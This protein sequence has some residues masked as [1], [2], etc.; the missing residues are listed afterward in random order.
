M[1]PSFDVYQVFTPTTQAQANF[2]DRKAINDQLVDALRTPGKQ[3]IVYG[4]SGS[5]KSTLL[6]NK[7]RQTYAAHITTQCSTVMTYEQLL[8]DAFDQLDQYYIEGRSTQKTRSISPSVVADFSRIRASINASML[9][10]KGNSESR[11]IPPQLTAQRLAQFL[12]EQQM[13]WVVEDFHKMPQN[14]KTP[15]AQSMKVFSDVSAVYPDVKTITIGATDTARQVVVYDP[16]MKNRVSELLVPLMTND[17]LAEII[18][19]GQK[20]L[21]I[22]LSE[23]A[24]PIVEYSVGVPSV[25]HQLAL[26]VCLEGQVMVTQISLRTLSGKLLKPAVA[27]YVREASDTLKAK[28]DSALRRHRVRKFDNCRLILAAIA[29]GPLSGMRPS[30]IL[31]VIRIGEPDYPVGNL[32]QYLKE[33]TQDARGSVIRLG[34]DGTYRFID[35]LYHTFAQATLLGERNRKTTDTTSVGFIAAS[36]LAEWYLSTS[37]TN[38]FVV[39]PGSQ[40]DTW[41]ATGVPEGLKFY[42]TDIL[43]SEPEKPKV[44]ASPSR[45]RRGAVIRPKNYEE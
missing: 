26:N 44:V 39:T 25:C 31:S 42:T 32:T 6:L 27:Q 30:E 3:L 18:E 38:S 35:P 19:N 11:L 43:R 5:G 4:E 40:F 20:L 23:L 13:C 16:E 15:F 9:N 8:L 17:E 22:D 36:V 21:C 33:L 24:S 37:M 2:I 12:G 41:K 45:R 10:A 29:T 1:S 7:L 14:E 28:F 34:I